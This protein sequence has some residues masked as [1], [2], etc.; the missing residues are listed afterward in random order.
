MASILAMNEKLNYQITDDGL[1]IKR[2]QVGKSMD[3][4]DLEMDSK[5]GFFGKK[6][7]SAFIDFV[8]LKSLVGNTAPQ[9]EEFFKLFDYLTFEMDENGS[10]LLIS[11]KNKT[12]NILVQFREAVYNIM[13][14]Q[15]NNS[16]LIDEI[17]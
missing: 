2:T 9:E 17:L 5:F 11:M 14:N 16:S 6:G 10:K 8:E 1:L 15:A 12:A 3:N 4:V 7:V 13:V